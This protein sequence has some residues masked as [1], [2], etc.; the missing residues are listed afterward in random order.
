MLDRPRAWAV[1]FNAVVE[2]FACSPDRFIRFLMLFS[3]RNRW[4]EL[5]NSVF[6]HSSSFELLNIIPS[7]CWECC[8]FVSA[9][10]LFFFEIVAVV[11]RSQ[12]V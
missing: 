2:R 12:A 6:C 3:L 10:L 5:G 4:V 8:L 11:P 9:R 7:C 1:R